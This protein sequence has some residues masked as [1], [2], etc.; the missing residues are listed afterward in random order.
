M[1][2]GMTVSVVA[3]AETVYALIGAALGPFATVWPYAVPSDVTVHANYNDGT[4]EQLLVQ[5]ADYTLAA[6]NPTLTNGGNVTLAGYLLANHGGVWPAGAQIAIARLTPRSQPSTFGE[7]VG[8]SPQASEQALDNISRQVQELT[9]QMRRTV[10]VD[11]GE[12]P[13]LIGSVA[14]SALWGVDAGGNFL[15]FIYGGNPGQLVG[16]DINGALTFY[17]API[18]GAGSGVGPQVPGLIASNGVQLLPWSIWSVRTL[19]GAFS[20]TLPKRSTIAPGAW[21][22]VADAEYHAGVNNYTV[23][24]FA[25][26]QISARGVLA[27]NWKLALSNQVGLFLNG[28]TSW[29]VIPYGS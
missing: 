12:T 1:L 7:A 5:G 27:N 17:P 16:T 13:P 3:A 26:D 10:R 19:L 2:R 11:Y 14:N 8:F 18:P 4:G 15:N 22:M 25:G 6:S 23:N 29:T 20:G 9:T 24:A 28:A 21:L